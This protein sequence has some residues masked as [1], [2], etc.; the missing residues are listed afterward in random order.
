VLYR[1]EINSNQKPKSTASSSD[2]EI[3][4][5]VLPHQCV[6]I[7][8][9]A[10]LRRKYSAFKY[11][12][13]QQGHHAPSFGQRYALYSSQL[14]RPTKRA[15]KEKYPYQPGYLSMLYITSVSS[16]YIWGSSLYRS[17]TMTSKARSKE[18]YSRSGEK[19]NRSRKERASRAHRMGELRRYVRWWLGREST[20]PEGWVMM[21]IA[22]GMSF[23]KAV[24][25][26]TVTGGEAVGYSQLRSV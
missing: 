14:Y 20:L 21:F 18:I 23:Q 22:R 26:D 11:K 6:I 25:H 13:G 9:F 3:H 16:T 10:S 19:T 8:L 17:C 1:R 15:Q 2:L 24:C 12:P 5:S 7:T 4:S